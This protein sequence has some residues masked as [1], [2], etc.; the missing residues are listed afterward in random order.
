MEIQRDISQ[1]DEPQELVAVIGNQNSHIAKLINS[2]GRYRVIYSSCGSFR[3]DDE[4]PSYEDELNTL[5]YV[6]KAI[7][8][9][10]NIDSFTL[11]NILGL[12]RGAG[13]ETI[14]TSLNHGEVSE[15]ILWRFSSMNMT[16]I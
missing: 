10:E 6:D 13:T 4:I 14:L 12:C 7:I 3:L 2:L 15:N 9:P 11:G 8:Y 5:E 16:I 1:E